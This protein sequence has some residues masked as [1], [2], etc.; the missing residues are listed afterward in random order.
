MPKTN[1][2]RMKKFASSDLCAV[3]K[4]IRRTINTCYSPVYPREVI[5]YFHDY[6]D[7]EN[8]LKDAKEGYTIVVKSNNRLIGTGTIVGN[9]IWRVFINPTFQK[10]GFGKLIMQKLE[11][12]AISN[13]ISLV[14]LNA[15]LPSK[16][17]YDALGYTT[18]EKTFLKVEND[19][20]LNYYKM[21]KS[22]IKNSGRGNSGPLRS[23]EKDK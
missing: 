2:I 14:E 23:G 15:S 5:N 10:Q 7:N 1:G 22:L 17:F 12:K 21:K 11:A 20:K 3:K 6:H 13:K 18:A 9:H 8:I 16:K 4:L 19:K